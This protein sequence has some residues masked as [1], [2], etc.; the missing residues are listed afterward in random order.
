MV[1]TGARLIGRITFQRVI[2]ELA[3]SSLAASSIS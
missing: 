3:P 1:A 2:Q